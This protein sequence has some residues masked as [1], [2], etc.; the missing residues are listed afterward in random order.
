MPDR[1]DQYTQ[2]PV[3]YFSGNA[4]LS[5][6]ISFSLHHRLVQGNHTA[7]LFHLFNLGAYALIKLRAVNFQHQLSIQVNTSHI[8]IA[9]AYQTDI[10][11]CQH[12]LCMHGLIAQILTNSN[13]CFQHISAVFEA[14]KAYAIVGGS[15]S[16]KSTL[17]NLLMGAGADYR[18][19]ILFDDMELHSIAPESLYTLLSAIQ[20][21]V[22]VFNASIKDNVSMFRDFPKQ[23]LEEVILHAHLQELLEKRTDHRKR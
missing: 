14:G 10:F 9:G 23:E 11:P 2:R 4:L 7:F 16:G 20:Q 17:L 21:N 8:R 12:R 13:A 3:K 18:G 6:C 15:G 19:R 5:G 22:F 1:Q